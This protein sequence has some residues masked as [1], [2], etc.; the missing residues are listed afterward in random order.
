V[1]STERP[2]ALPALS[3]AL[4]ALGPPEARSP[5]VVAAEARTPISALRAALAAVEATGAKLQL[6]VALPPGTALPADPVLPPEAA[7]R[8]LCP[9]GL[10]DLPQGAAEGD[11]DVRELRAALGAL[12]RTASRCLGTA[13]PAGTGGGRF[14]LAV[15]VA[16]E[17]R[18]SEACATRDSAG[19]PALRACVLEAVRALDLPRPAPP[20]FVDLAFPL[21]LVPDAAA[22]QR[23]SCE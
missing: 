15:R 8:G 23:A 3:A 7:T 2:I 10:R 19:D 5:V 13:G 21:L 17:G 9:G 1:S 18:V 6:G 16:P 12:S 20:G 11:V 22:N 4:A 14:E